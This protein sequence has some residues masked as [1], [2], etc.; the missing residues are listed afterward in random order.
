MMMIDEYDDSDGYAITHD[1]QIDRRIDRQI[2]VPI[3]CPLINGCYDGF[4]GSNY[5][6]RRALIMIMMKT[7]PI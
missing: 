3:N 7:I 6:N 2:L 4:N 5:F 1:I